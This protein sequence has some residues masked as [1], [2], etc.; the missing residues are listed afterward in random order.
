M[1]DNR[2]LVRRMYDELSNGN[3]RLLVEL[4]ADDVSWTV[5]GRT[6]W[7]GTYRGKA[8]VLKDLLGQLTAR[9][10]GRYRASAHRILADGD[11]VVA[12]ARAQ[13]VTKRGAPYDQEYCF[14]F[15]FEDGRI[16][17][18]SEYMDTELVTSALGAI[19]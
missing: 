5:M 8:A 15:R 11:Y 4:L 9:L 17:E 10:E 2:D 3:S 16:H 6:K 14:V 12:E 18:V 7:S 19:E 13:A 1:H